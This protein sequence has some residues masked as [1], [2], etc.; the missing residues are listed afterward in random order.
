MF[1]CLLLFFLTA[2]FPFPGE[3][4]EGILRVLTNITT[5]KQR[6]LLQDSVKY[7]DSPRAGGHTGERRRWN[8]DLVCVLQSRITIGILS[9]AFA[10]LMQGAAALV[11]VF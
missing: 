6:C 9:G 4:L 10:E 11:R 7:G 3:L 2:P 5:S 1:V 8:A